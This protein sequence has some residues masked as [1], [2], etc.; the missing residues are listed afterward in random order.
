MCCQSS[1]QTGPGPD[2]TEQCAGSRWLGTAC[3][4]G[5]CHLWVSQPSGSP[6]GT[7]SGS[8]KRNQQHRVC[9]QLMESTPTSKWSTRTSAAHCML[10]R[11]LGTWTSATCWFRFG[12]AA[13]SDLSPDA[14]HVCWSE[15]TPGSYPAVLS[16]HHR[17]AVSC[18]LWPWGCWS[19][20]SSFCWHQSPCLQSPTLCGP[21]STRLV[22]V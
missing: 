13:R 12:G 10:Q 2:Q 8:S 14:L 6:G 3:W 1:E 11:K 5:R 16:G 7:I 17:K 9:S 22:L 20:S 18:P 15:V 21:V 19:C 4:S